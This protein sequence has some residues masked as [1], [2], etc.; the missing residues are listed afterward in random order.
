[1][2]LL[3][4]ASEFVKRS[5]ANMSTSDRVMASREAKAIVLSINE[6]Y[7]K[8]KD[9]N[10]MDIMKSVTYKKRKIDRRLRGMLG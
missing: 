6:V 1:M 7:K 4:K 8:T 2:E 5:M 3:N 10:L 9:P